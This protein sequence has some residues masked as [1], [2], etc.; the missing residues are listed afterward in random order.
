MSG[1]Y[2]P[3]LFGCRLGLFLK[4]A[5]GNGSEI[6]LL[7]QDSTIDSRT[8]KVYKPGG[9]YIVYLAQAYHVKPGNTFEA[10]LMPT[11]G[12]YGISER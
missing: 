9:L 7:R 4:S 1:H 6:V 11:L 12:P 2:H 3:G 8:R 5:A 10:Q